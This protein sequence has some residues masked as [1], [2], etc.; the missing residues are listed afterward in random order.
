MPQ[1]AREVWERQTKK[2]QEQILKE[3]ITIC[4]G[5]MNEHIRINNSLSPSVSL[6]RA[7]G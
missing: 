5:I 6:S 7:S 2:Q 4:Q 3:L 1:K